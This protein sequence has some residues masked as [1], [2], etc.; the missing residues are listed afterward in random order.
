MK[1]LLFA[2]YV[3]FVV[4]VWPQFMRHA[5][6]RREVYAIAREVAYDTEAGPQTGLRLMQVAGQES[7][8]YRGAVGRKGE[9]GPWQVLG[10][11][12][13]SA[14]EAIRRMDL[15]MVSFVGCR[16]AEDK[17]TLPEG[18]KTT[19]LEMVDHRIGPAD[20]YLSEHPPPPAPA[21]EVALD[22]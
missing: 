15:G 12:D 18:T 2:Y 13:Y 16:H 17:V 11:S 20:R 1:I 14:R 21:A 19:C 22:P 7:G 10:G 4:D 3:C 9:R 6:Q 5:W 8:F